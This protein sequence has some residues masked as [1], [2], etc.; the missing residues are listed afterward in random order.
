MSKLKIG[1]I[2]C[3]TIGS[4]LAFTVD[5]ELKGKANLVGIC[6]LD[7]Q[8]AKKL[9]GRL[10]KKPA[11]L[12]ITD[13]FKKSDLVIEA[14]HPDVA[15][16]VLK[17]ALASKKDIMLMSVGGVLGSENLLRQA[18]KKNIKVYLPSG[19]VAGID[20]I[21]AAKQAGIKTV[22]LITRKPPGGLNL[23]NIKGEKVIF[24]GTA[25]QAIKKYPKNINVSAI[26]SLSSINAKKVR[27]KII[28]SD[29][30]KRNS[31]QITVEGKFGKLSAT[32]ENVPS[33]ENPK[34]SYLA[35]LSAIQTLKQILLS[36]K[37]GT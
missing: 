28:T 22:R 30:F 19:A 24:D 17:Q 6:D 9:Q 25:F 21:K 36:I 31:H 26:L 11:L 37:I 32:T 35:I 3:G 34:T 7:L 16:K 2:G 14:A 29:K 5:R 8:K 12:H 33:P 4:R 10:K 23:K 1:I 27:V 15:K 20:A 18:E 13:L